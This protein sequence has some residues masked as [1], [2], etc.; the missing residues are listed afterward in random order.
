MYRSRT[1]PERAANVAFLEHAPLTPTSCRRVGDLSEN[2]LG[3]LVL[4]GF[5]LEGLLGES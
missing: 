3:E 1:T 5:Y 2:Q 4:Q